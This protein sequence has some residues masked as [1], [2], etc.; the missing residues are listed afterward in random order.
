M[1]WWMALFLCEVQSFQEHKFNTFQVSKSLQEHK[2]GWRK[3][4]QD[5][6]TSPKF[7]KTISSKLEHM[8][9]DET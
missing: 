9:I 5:L 1:V 7:L 4:N 8:R 2:F 3:R 6:T